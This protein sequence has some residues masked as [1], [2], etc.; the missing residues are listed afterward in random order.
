MKENLKYI[1]R[2]TGMVTGTWLK[3]SFFFGSISVLSVFLGLF[4]LLKD[5]SA[6]ASGHAG[7]APALILMFLQKPVGSILWLLLIVCV[8]LVTVFTGKYVIAKL[9]NRLVNDQSEKIIVPLLDKIISGTKALQPEAMRRGIDAS[10][11]K[12]QMSEQLKKTG[13]NKWMKRI[14]QFALKRIALDD[15]DFTDP[16]LDLDQVIKNKILQFLQ[17]LTEPDKNAFWF[18]LVFQVLALLFMAFFHF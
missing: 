3:I 4:F 10:I 15:V 1:A 14:L 13:E 12:I 8:Y 5:V 18:I 17:N 2:L 11:V 9:I 16:K 7:A 6:G